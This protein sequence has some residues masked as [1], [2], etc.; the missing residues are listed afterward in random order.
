[1]G[2]VTVKSMTRIVV[3]DG[4]DPLGLDRL[5]DEAD[6]AV[7]AGLDEP[8]LIAALGDADAVIVRSKSRLTGRVLD[9]APH[10]RVAARAGVVR[11][12]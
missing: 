8:A 5:R 1:M 10:L 3:A 7:F 9:A 4:L 12:M 2:G 6:V 11:P